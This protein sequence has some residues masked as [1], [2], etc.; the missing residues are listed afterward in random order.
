[1]N[2]LHT[3]ERPVFDRSITPTD[4]RQYFTSTRDIPPQLRATARDRTLP[5]STVTRQAMGD[6]ERPRCVKPDWQTE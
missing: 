2:E 3:E 1:M 6:P 5:R 4:I